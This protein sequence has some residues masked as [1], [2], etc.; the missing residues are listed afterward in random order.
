MD[1]ET[2][3]FEDSN[4][5]MLGSD[6]EKQVKLAAAQTEKCWEVSG[7]DQEFKFGE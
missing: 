6:L 2:V 1:K 7:K 5:A 3:N 4:I